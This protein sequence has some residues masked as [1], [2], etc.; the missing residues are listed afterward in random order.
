MHLSLA[1]LHGHAL[2]SLSILEGERSEP[3][4]NLVDIRDARSNTP[5]LEVLYNLRGDLSQNV[6][7]AEEGTVNQD[8]L[9]I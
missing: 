5:A 3:L 8:A 6:L 9:I 2:V 7:K 4:L 1:P